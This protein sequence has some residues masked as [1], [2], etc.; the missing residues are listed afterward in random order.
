MELDLLQIHLL[1]VMR[2]SSMV[3]FAGHFGRWGSS[4]VK[5]FVEIAEIWRVYEGKV[6]AV[7]GTVHR[8]CWEMKRLDV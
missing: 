2:L 8:S 1:F 6:S 4:R 3:V 7:D 5:F